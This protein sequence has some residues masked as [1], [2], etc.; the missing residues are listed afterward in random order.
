[1]A[2]AFNGGRTARQIVDL[3]HSKTRQPGLLAPFSPPKHRCTYHKKGCVNR[4]D[5][6]VT[7]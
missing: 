7:R 6:R 2:Q 5:F 3:H 4:E 1:M